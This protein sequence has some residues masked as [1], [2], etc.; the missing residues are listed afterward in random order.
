MNTIEYASHQYVE[1]LINGFAPY[2]TLSSKSVE[3]AFVAGVEFAQQW[4]SVNDELPEVD[5]SGE[6][7]LIIMKIDH[8]CY[9]GYYNAENIKNKWIELITKKP[10]NPTHWRP[11]NLK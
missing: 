9:T 7:D 5:E 3:N 10:Y 4:I 8:F 1:H 6:S 2:M 11:I